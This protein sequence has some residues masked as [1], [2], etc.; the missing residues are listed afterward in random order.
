MRPA[1]MPIEKELL[2]IAARL[3]A[4][5]PGSDEA[6]ALRAVAGELARART[7][8]NE[9]RPVGRVEVRHVICTGSVVDTREDGSGGVYIE[10]WWEMNGQ[11]LATRDPRDSAVNRR[12]GDNGNGQ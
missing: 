11:H 6:T 2:E 4:R 8:S 5:Q 1:Q 3:A 9:V 10:Q 7:G 12:D